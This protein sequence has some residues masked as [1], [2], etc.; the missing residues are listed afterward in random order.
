M[1]VH[2]RRCLN[3]LALLALLAVLTVASSAQEAGPFVLM[4]S[5]DGM[6]PVSY[7]QDGPARI[8]TMRQLARDGAWAEG[9]TGVL[10]TVTYP[11]HTTMITGVLPARH[12][13]VGNTIL[14][15]EGRSR[16]AWYWYARQIK[17]PTL[18]GVVRARGLTAGA[19]SWPVTVGMDLDFL[20]P[21][22]PRSEHAE[23][24]HMLAALSRPDSLFES[25]ER[26]FGTPDWPLTDDNRA[27]MAAWILRTFRPNLLL[28]HIFDND[29]ASH[30]FGPDSPQALAA[31]EENDKQIAQILDAAQQAG[32]R[33]RLNVVI[34]SDH[35]FVDLHHRLQ[36]NT[37]FRE[38]GLLQVDENGRITAWQAYFKPAGGSAEIYIAPDAGPEVHA[39]VKDLLD[40]VARDEANGIE[41]V[42]TPEELAEA[43]GYPNAAFAVTMRP[44]YYTGAAHDGLLVPLKGGG[45]H[46]FD[47][48]LPELK[49][50]LIMSGPDVAR[51]GSLGRV[52]M[53]QIAPTI[54]QW[55]GVQLAP[56]V[57]EPLFEKATDD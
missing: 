2:M 29:S 34:V 47:P 52:R 55:F 26:E 27:N 6:R 28:L 41:K 33:D 21:E 23:S 3:C 22:F 30:E 43:G 24:L 40:E 37:L 32:L 13:I 10:P 48:A 14:D 19:V 16:N 17:V 25:Y 20:V 35:G 45:G 39:R 49:A 44:G 9:V 42:W 4:I 50:S 1:T 7:L 5:V 15:P 46:G 54:A 31:L 57:D 8:P 12:G 18:P 38:R 53:T 51:R 11:S 56:G 36:L